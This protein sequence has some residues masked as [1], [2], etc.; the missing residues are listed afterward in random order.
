[1]S[2]IPP[3][4]ISCASGNQAQTE[5]LIQR[6]GSLVEILGHASV[7][8]TPAD[9]R[10]AAHTILAF[11]DAIEGKKTAQEREAAITDLLDAAENLAD[12]ATW[13][14]SDSVGTSELL[15]ATEDMNY[16]RAAMK[17]LESFDES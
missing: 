11:T 12:S 8:L 2:E 7:H 4:Y 5:L 3:T 16:L 6:H 9:A 1:V 17:T 13:Y 14:P 10:K 15:V